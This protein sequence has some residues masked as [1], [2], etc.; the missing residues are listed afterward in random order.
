MFNKP[1]GNTNASGSKDLIITSN[2]A[3]EETEAQGGQVTSV[4]S[5]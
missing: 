4:V 3:D 1:P 5:E 2:S